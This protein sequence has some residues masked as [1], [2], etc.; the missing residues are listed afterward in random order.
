[1]ENNTFKE[2]FADRG[3][4][5]YLPLVELGEH[6]ATEG[7]SK[8]IAG[9]IMEDICAKNPGINLYSL[10][11]M[12]LLAN[13]FAEEDGLLPLT[14]WENNGDAQLSK[15]MKHDFQIAMTTIWIAQC[16][17]GISNKLSKQSLKKIQRT[18]QT[19]LLGYFFNQIVGNPPHLLSV[20][21]SALTI[22]KYGLLQ[23]FFDTSK[24][25]EL[26]KIEVLARIIQLCS[27]EYLRPGNGVLL[28]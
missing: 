18:L 5:D 28:P 7:T 13:R 12:A 14:N 6:F 2:H 26:Q 3:N 11:D 27:L 21:I 4:R 24:E 17:S 23:W 19:C 9:L 20:Q 25:R 1:M 10:H 15:M 22:K 8:L 16:T